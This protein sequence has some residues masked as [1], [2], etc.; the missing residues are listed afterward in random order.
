MYGALYV[1]ADLDEY[2]ANPEGYLTGNPLPIKDAL[3]KDRR[4]RTEWKY[5]ELAPLLADLSVGR[6]HSGGKQMFTVAACVACHKLENVGNQFGPELTLL[7]PKWQP[8]DILKEM[9]D[10]SAR[11][12]EKFQTSVFQLDSGQTIT[13]LVV[14][15]TPAA[16]KVIENPLAKA[17]TIEVKKA[18]IVNQ[19]KSPVSIMPKGL[20]DKLTREEILDLVAYVF[21]KGD[22]ANPIYSAGGANHGHGGHGH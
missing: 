15:E 8:A 9:L 17:V 1:V 19:K 20:L 11:I 18:E 3:L 12:N 6:S 4:P 14:E 22:K 13:G 5:E 21:A 10:P 2:E 7:D 16:Y